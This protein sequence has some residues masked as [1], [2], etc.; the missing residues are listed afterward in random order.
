MFV[1]VVV[2]FCC[3]TWLAF[4]ILAYHSNQLHQFFC[5]SELF[6]MEAILSFIHNFFWKLLVLFWVFWDS[7][8]NNFC[9]FLSVPHLVD[10]YAKIVDGRGRN[11]MCHRT[12]PSRLVS[13]IDDLLGTYFSHSWKRQIYFHLLVG[14]I[15]KRI[16]FGK[17]G[18]I[19]TLFWDRVFFM[20]CE[21][22][23]FA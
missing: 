2:W 8:K 10:N 17:F 18:N 22:I 20:K 3:S 19:F 16:L 5:S 14:F 21:K 4:L 7:Q 6:A 1:V 12:L 13:F 23:G 9:V 11:L 15:K